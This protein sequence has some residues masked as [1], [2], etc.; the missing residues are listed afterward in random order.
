MRGREGEVGRVIE[1]MVCSDSGSGTTFVH[2]DVDKDDGRRGGEVD[3]FEMGSSLDSRTL[4]VHEDASDG[5]E[6]EVGAIEGMNSG[7]GSGSG[8]IFVT[9]GAGVY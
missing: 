8:W 4:F 2:E 6:G 1:G 9:E 3:V 5:A 7:S